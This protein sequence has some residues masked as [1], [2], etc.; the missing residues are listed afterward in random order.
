MSSK[1][2]IY[3]FYYRKIKKYD[4]AGLYCIYNYPYEYLIENILKKKSLINLPYIYFKKIIP[5][6]VFEIIMTYDIRNIDNYLFWN[7]D[8]PEIVNLTIKLG[9]TKIE[10]VLED[11]AHRKQLKKFKLFIDKKV[12]ER[13]MYEYLNDWAKFRST[14]LRNYYSS[15]EIQRIIGYY[16]K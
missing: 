5:I 2:F 1:Y 8:Y 7:S 11:A 12:F 16:L 13:E 6:D 3:L 14:D 4:L 15:L 9:A 10:W